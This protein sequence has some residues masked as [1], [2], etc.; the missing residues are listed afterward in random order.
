ML[1][2]TWALF[3]AAYRELNAKKLF[4]ITMGINLLAVVL[5][6]SFGI[7]E[8]GIT[9]LHWQIDAEFFN[10]GNIS[11]GL[12]YRFL[13]ANFFIPVWLT[14]AATILALISTAG[15]IPDLVRGGV[16]ETML[17]KPISRTRLFLTRYAT[18]LLFV[19]GQ[20]GVFTLGCLLVMG[21]RGGVWDVQ[22]FLAVPIVLVFYS[23][24]FG[25]CALLGILTRSTITALLL[26]LV[27]WLLLWTTNEADEYLI[28]Q[29]SGA[30]IR[31][32]DLEEQETNRQSLL[33]STLRRASDD[34]DP[35]DR[36]LAERAVDTQ[37]SRLETTQTELAQ[38]RE[39]LERWQTWTGYIGMARSVLPKTSETIGLLD[40]Y[41]ISQEELERLFMQES[42]VRIDSDGEDPFA[43]MSD[44]RVIQ[45]SEEAMRDRSVLWIVGTSLL[46][47][48][49]VLGLATLLFVRRDF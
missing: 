12:F 23:Y 11:S 20:V 27:V 22:L 47:E 39:T 30:E 31:V 45:R 48:A 19:L 10:T 5:F 3:V 33:D 49:L 21:I 17:S 32:E 9:L 46:F 7:N 1:T 35:A 14:W 8:Q 41:L 34:S 40:R 44:P 26:T 16:I 4:W 37:R 42:G 38:A 36:E 25:V 18:G 6:G 15:I 29:R 2:Q 28:L 43:A 24:L 13:F